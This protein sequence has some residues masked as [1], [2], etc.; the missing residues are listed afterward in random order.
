MLEVGDCVI[1]A[2]TGAESLTAR[3]RTGLSLP[4]VSKSLPAPLTTLSPELLTTVLSSIAGH[5][6][7]APRPEA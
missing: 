7:I 3:I 1:V 2:R 4:P 5:R 6:D